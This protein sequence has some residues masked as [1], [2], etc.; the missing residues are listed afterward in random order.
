MR[1]R[2]AAVITLVTGVVL[3]TLYLLLSTRGTYVTSDGA[4][5]ALQAWAM[6]HGNL[7]LHGWTV[8]DVPFYTTELPEYMLVEAIRGLGPE[9]VHTSAALT[10]TLLILLSAWLAVPR[11]ASGRQ[12]IVPAVMTAA[13]MLAPEPGNPT[14]VLLLSPDHVGTCV[15]LL[16]IWLIIDRAVRD[17][18]AGTAARWLVPVTVGVLLAWTAVADPIAEVIGAAPLAC[19]GAV[20]IIQA[21]VRR[22]PLPGYEVSL[23]V[24]ALLSVAAARVATRLIAAAG[25]WTAAPVTTSLI[26]PGLLGSHAALTGNGILQLFGADM[27]SQ[28]TVTG[29]IFAVLHLAGLALA[30]AGLGLAIRHFFRQDL[31]IQV[32]AV[33]IVVILLSY[34]LTYEAQDIASTRDIAAV[35]PFGAVLAG[36]LLAGQDVPALSARTT[37]IAAA[38]LSAGY[39]VMLAVNLASPPVPGGSARLAAWLGG[40]HLTSGLAGYWQA[41]A[42]TVD[43]G[44]D[45]V[46]R[47]INLGPGRP[48][49]G[50][51][52]EANA[53][54]YGPSAPP[55][56]FVVG[57]PGPGRPAARSPGRLVTQMEALAGRPDKIY[58]YDG[59]VIAEWRENLLSRLG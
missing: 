42:V 36:R 35:L 43:S 52:W 29:I 55:A 8:S 59:Y 3:F 4:S 15:P 7:L 44:G 10:Y 22:Q 5:N 9:V 56:D 39:A 45:V 28:P 19:T 40:Q 24:A 47:A 46:L 27:A 23:T 6:L 30:A 11:G 58:F 48:V 51:D 49:A 18:A 31:V 37:A 14:G 26:S 12:A 32:L 41:N 53:A 38:V 1:I 25:G 34:L 20:R 54:W 21:R 2:W 13:I 17:G 33:A 50:S 57:I 16:L